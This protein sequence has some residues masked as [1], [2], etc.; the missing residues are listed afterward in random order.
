MTHPSATT[1]LLI[2]LR[3]PGATSAPELLSSTQDLLQARWFR[4]LLLSPPQPLREAAHAREALQ[5]QRR[6]IVTERARAALLGSFVADAACM[7]AHWVPAEQIAALLL[8]RHACAVRQGCAA[9][10]HHLQTAAP[11]AQGSRVPARV[12]GPPSGQEGNPKFGSCHCRP[13]IGTDTAAMRAQYQY[14]SGSLS[15]LGDEVLPTLQS[16][17]KHGGLY[18]PHLLA[19]S[20]QFFTEQASTG[21]SEQG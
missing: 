13:A 21:C 10:G 4:V 18:G 7:G 11:C 6:D 15:A 14:S 1:S 16:L 12:S 8:L 3:E 5:A 2:V 20:H 19:T 9:A 17:L